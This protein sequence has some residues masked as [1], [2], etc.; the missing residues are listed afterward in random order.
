MK[1]IEFSPPH[2]NIAFLMWLDFVSFR[3][4][5]KVMP[6]GM[7]GDWL[8]AGVTRLSFLGDQMLRRRISY[9]NQSF[10]CRI[11]SRF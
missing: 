11:Q 10:S 2:D 8:T 1:N 4:W 5:Y 7:L 3:V 6:V 9:G